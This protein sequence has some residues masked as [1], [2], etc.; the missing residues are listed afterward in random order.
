[1]IRPV[2][3]ALASLVQARLNCIASGNMEWWVRHEERIDAL[4]KNA[5]PKGSGFDAGTTLDLDR[6]TG[7]KLV[8]QTSYHHLTEGF[9]DGWTDHTVTVTASM[10]GGFDLKISGK[11]RDG[12]KDFIADAFADALRQEVTRDGRLVAFV[13]PAYSA[14]EAQ[15]VTEIIYTLDPAKRSLVDVRVA[16]PEKMALHRLLVSDI[17]AAMNRRALDETA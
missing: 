10:V 2:F 7:A 6:S 5:L 13:Q 16:H 8:L 4:V 12:I 3:S 14:Q 17:L 9:Y 15:G 1:M 11:D